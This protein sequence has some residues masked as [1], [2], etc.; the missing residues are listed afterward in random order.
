[1]FNADLRQAR[2][3]I[4]S[5]VKGTLIDDEMREISV[6]GRSTFTSADHIYIDSQSK[7]FPTE[8]LP[9]ISL[10]GEDHGSE[11]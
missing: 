11:K 4:R 2:K 5:A 3:R 8:I 7:A 1:L 6:I 9:E 10:S